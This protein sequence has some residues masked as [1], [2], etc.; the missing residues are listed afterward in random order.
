MQLDEMVSEVLKGNINILDTMFEEEIKS[1]FKYI[2]LLNLEDSY[3]SKLFESLK[4][5]YPSL[6]FLLVYDREIYKDF[7]ISILNK[8]FSLLFENNF[9]SDFIGSSEWSLEFIKNNISI[10]VEFNSDII[11]F[12]LRYAFAAKNSDILSFLVNNDNLKVRGLAMVEIADNYYWEFNKIYQDILSFI[13][14][15]TSDG[16]ECLVDEFYVSRVAYLIVENNLG[17]EKYQ[18][19]KRFIFDNYLCNS[20]AKL[21]DMGMNTIE[22]GYDYGRYPEL[23][24]EDTT[25]FFLTSKEYKFV[26]YK[27]KRKY[28]DKDVWDYFDR[29]IRYFSKVDEAIISH[30]FLCGLGDRFLEYVDKYLEKSTG[31]KL[32]SVIG[33]RGSTTRAFRVGDYVVKCS[34]AKWNISEVPE[35]LY[36]FAKCYEKDYVKGRMGRVVGALEVQKYYAKPVE[37]YEERLINKFREA[38][39]DEGYIIKDNVIGDNGT[40]NLYRLDNYME[41]DCDNPEILP[42]WFKKNPVV[43]VDLDLVYKIK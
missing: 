10:L 13:K 4:N 17:I 40:H 32:I 11:Y 5:N 34:L 38:L 39:K 42:K 37:V 9:L 7:C 35:S 28:I 18:L 23:L 15:S 19:L 14:F 1:L 36:L 16:K 33:R 41:A 30:I 22:S 2:H 3:V 21:L 27:K 43:W 20:L 29:K 8:D 25:E 6:V 31:C 26:L 24:N 12:T